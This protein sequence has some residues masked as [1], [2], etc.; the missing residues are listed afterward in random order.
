MHILSCPSFSNKFFNFLLVLS[1]FFSVTSADLLT[2][3][4]FLETSSCLE[5]IF[6]DSLLRTF[7]LEATAPRIL[8]YNCKNINSC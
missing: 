6:L 8:S 3:L 1:S 4:T 5:P 7:M 2:S